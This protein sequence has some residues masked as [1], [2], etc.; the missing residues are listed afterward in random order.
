MRIRISRLFGGQMALAL[1][2]AISGPK[3]VSIFRAHPLSMALG[4]DVAPN[5]NHYVPRHIN[6]RYINS[7]DRQC[8]GRDKYRIKIVLD[9]SSHSNLRSRFV[10]PFIY[11]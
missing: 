6:N 5:Q 3:K 2:I 8:E 11:Y 7:Y 10:F 1:L 4:M 9:I